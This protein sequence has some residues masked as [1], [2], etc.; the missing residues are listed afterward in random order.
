MMPTIVTLAETST[1]GWNYTLDAKYFYYLHGPLARTELGDYNQKV[2]GLDYAYTLHGWLKSVNGASLNH[3]RDMGKDGHYTLPNN[4]NAKFGRDAFGFML[5]YY[6]GDYTP[7]GGLSSNFVPNFAGSNILT[8]KNDLFNGNIPFMQTSLPDVNAYN[9]NG[10]VVNSSLGNLYQYDQLNRLVEHRVFDNFNIATNNWLNTP[11]NNGTDKFYENFTYDANGN[12][13][14]INRNGANT[15]TG[16]AMDNFTYR[17]NNNVSQVIYPSSSSTGYCTYPMQSNKLYHV[18]DAVAASNYTDDVDDQGSFTPSQNTINTANNYGY[19][20]IGNLVRDNAE[21]IQEITWNV[22]GKIESISRTGN[23]NKPNLAFTYDA[24]GQRISKTVMPRNNGVLSTEKDWTTTY[25]VRDATG[26]VMATYSQTYT[27]LQ[28]NQIKEEIKLKELHLYG[29]SRLGIVNAN[30]VMATQDYY[31]PSY[32]TS[33]G[34]FVNPSVMFNTLVTTEVSPLPTIFTIYK[35]NKQYE[36]SNHLGNVLA[37]ISDRRVPRDDNGDLLIDYFNADILSTSDYY[38]FGSNMSTRVIGGYRYSFNGKERDDESFNDAY[39]FGARIYDSRLGRWLSLDPLTR[40]FSYQTP[41]ASFDNNPIYFTDPTGMSSVGVK[42]D[43]YGKDGKYLGKDDK[44]DNLVYITTEGNYNY[45][46][47]KSDNSNPNYDALRS[48]SNLLGIFNDKFQQFAGII[49]RETEPISGMPGGGQG[50]LNEKK[51]LGGAINNYASKYNI[52]ISEYVEGE[53]NAGIGPLL[54]VNND[55]LN[56]QSAFAAA[57]YVLTGGQ[58]MSNGA[59]AWDGLDQAAMSSAGSYKGYVNHQNSW[60]WSISDEHWETW[61]GSVKNSKWAKNQLLGWNK[62]FGTSNFAASQHTLNNKGKTRAFS[63]ASYGSTIFWKLNNLIKMK[64]LFI[65]SLITL[66]FSCSNSN[67][68]NHSIGSNILKKSKVDSIVDLYSLKYP[69][70]IYLKYELL[71]LNYDKKLDLVLYFSG[72]GS[73]PLK[74]IKVFIYDSTKDKFELNKQLSLVENPSF[75]LSD[76]TITGFY[77]GHGGGYGINLKWNSLYWDT[78]EYLKFYPAFD[79]TAKWEVDVYNYNLNKINKI[80]VE[81]YQ[82]PGNKLLRNN[83]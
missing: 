64:Y 50:S 16:L 1:D 34:T 20:E 14:N 71:D 73:G 17:Y 18:N 45:T 44:N 41:Y 43:F 83:Y 7:V 30:R 61:T 24:A 55:N 78:I 38:A 31:I 79:N 63:S 58:D 51:A 4:A 53:G 74:K 37:T 29:S 11:L 68:H 65:L 15:G 28:S 36:L 22:Y 77:I 42:G 46:T 5:H 66:L 32:N 23:N 13:L 81:N 72:N 54:L 25:Y 76:T 2:Q 9:T 27:D 56:T 67:I 70:L 19:D 49:N 57:I 39:D 6:D 62:K 59:T 60:G 82:V 26:N 3:E 48:T 69:E 8:F 12:I 40:L 33:N 80:K 52:S 35:G 47:G 10:A 75:Y 21:N